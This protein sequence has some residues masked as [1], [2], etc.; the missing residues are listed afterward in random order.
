[1]SHVAAV[2]WFTLVK[3]FITALYI[4]ESAYIN[5]D[6]EWYVKRCWSSSSG[7][8][9]FQTNLLILLWLYKQVYVLHC[10]CLNLSEKEF[11]YIR[12]YFYKRIT[13]WF[14]KT[15]YGT[16]N[17][18]HWVVAI[19]CVFFFSWPV[20]VVYYNISLKLVTY[21]LNDMLRWSGNISFYFFIYYYMSVSKKKSLS[22][23]R[24]VS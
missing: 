17:L 11:I 9:K 12:T 24:Q 22:T 21:G 20:A 6:A 23:S 1:M 10:C 18:K 15:L 7:P 19:N 2:P 13:R 8:S 4:D 16:K 3:W 5:P 14:R